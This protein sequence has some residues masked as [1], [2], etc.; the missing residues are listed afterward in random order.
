MAAVCN[1]L[2]TAL[3]GDPALGLVDAVKEAA[4][5]AATLLQ[6]ALHSETAARVLTLYRYTRLQK[7]LMCKGR[8]RYAAAAKLNKYLTAVYGETE[9]QKKV[10][11]GASRLF[12]LF[13]APARD[14]E[15]WP[16]LLGEIVT[17]VRGGSLKHLHEALL[18]FARHRRS[19]AKRY[20]PKSRLQLIRYYL[21]T[22]QWTARQIEADL[23]QM[24]VIAAEHPLPAAHAD[25]LPASPSPSVHAASSPLLQQEPS[26][27][28]SPASA[29]DQVESHA[30]AQ[31]PV[32][33][34]AAEEGA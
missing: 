4:Y 34:E 23:Q 17:C 6:N 2:L 24:G 16:S 3:S 27:P 28:L 19:I 10:S 25:P 20:T 9:W 7:K 31:S 13:A 8:S 30:L 15:W 21:L 26:A 22:E 12:Q 11:S 1:D 14:D 18:M 29:S 5:S 32:D 33:H